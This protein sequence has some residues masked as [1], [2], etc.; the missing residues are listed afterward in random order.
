MY[1]ITP[2]EEPTPRHRSAR[3]KEKSVDVPKTPAPYPVRVTYPGRLKNDLEKLDT[4]KLDDKFLDT[5]SKLPNRSRYIRR[6]LCTKEQMLVADKILLR[7]SIN[8]MPYSLFKKLELGELTPT[9]VTIQLADHTI[10]YPKG[11]VENILVKVNRF[12]Y[13]TDFVVMDIKEDLNTP[14]VL[15]WPFMNTDRTVIDMYNQTRVLRSHEESVTYR[16]KCLIC[17]YK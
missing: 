13:P 17:F 1:S 6:L 12:L 4:F 2:E 16:I 11:I 3:L 14:I 9:K 7:E 10:R 5:M 15:G 8:L